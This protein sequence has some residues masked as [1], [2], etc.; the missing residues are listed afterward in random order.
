MIGN[1]QLSSA[2]RTRLILAA[3]LGF[4]WRSTPGSTLAPAFAG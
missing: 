4:R 2:S 1:D 3:L